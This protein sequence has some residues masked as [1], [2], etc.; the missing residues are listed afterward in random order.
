MK[1]FLILPIIFLC[2]CACKQVIQDPSADA[3]DS[4]DLTLVHSPCEATPGR[5][6]DVCRFSHGADISSVWRVII[7]HGGKVVGGEV[8]VKYKDHPWKSFAA[9]GPVVAIPWAEIVGAEKWQVGHEDLVT[10]LAKVSYKDA[11][12]I[13]QL[14]QA[15]GSAQILVLEPDYMPMPIDSGYESYEAK[16]ECK[17]QYSTAGRSALQCKEK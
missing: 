5:G 12:G 15:E 6:M 2:A 11:T 13:V 16:F 14:A 1:H 8:G 17:V 7:P 9:E 3:V 10:M 4:G